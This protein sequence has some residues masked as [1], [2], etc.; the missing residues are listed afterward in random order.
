MPLTKTFKELVQR[1]AS[2]DPEFAAALLREGI[3]T[4]VVSDINMEAGTQRGGD[5]SQPRAGQ[6]NAR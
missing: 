2:C 4:A 3:D 5:D 6:R 1:R